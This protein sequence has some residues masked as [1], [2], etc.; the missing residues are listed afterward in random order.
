[1]T[2]GRAQGGSK[3]GG[4]LRLEKCAA[5][6]GTVFSIVLYGCDRA[7]MDSAVEEAFRELCRIEHLLSNYLPSSE[8]SRINRDAASR[9]VEVSAELFDILADCIEYS[10]KSDGAFDISVRPLVDA[11]G[12]SGGNGRLPEQ[13]EV[14]AARARVGYRHLHLDFRKRTVQF[15]NP[16]MELDSGGIGKGYAVDRMAEKLRRAGFDRAM[17]VG[18]ASSIYGMGAPPAEPRGW[19][20]DI[21]FASRV[22]TTTFLKDMA[23]ST[24]GIAEKSFVA[25]GRVYSHVMD[26]RTGCP[27][28]N[29]LLASVMSPRAVDGE[30]WAKPCFIRGRDWVAQHKPAGFRVY[31][32]EDTPSGAGV[33][34]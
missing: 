4:L 27:A 33:W 23:L 2:P 7:G 25:G 10:R 6:M 14:S 28:P 8:W 34:L 20:I 21:R 9:P 16:G 12:F 13:A 29:M 31:L 32:H 17:I 3:E 22:L 26:P 15:D 11:W 18:S 5:A 30:A 19:P 1:M 24:T